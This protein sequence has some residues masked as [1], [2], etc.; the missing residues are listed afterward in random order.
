[1]LSYLV[2][3]A[4]I[5]HNP[6]FV[7]IDKVLLSYFSCLRRNDKR[8]FGTTNY[9]AQALGLHVGEVEK[10]MERIESVGLIIRESDNTLWLPHSLDYLKAWFPARGRDIVVGSTISE[11]LN[12]LATILS[13][14]RKKASNE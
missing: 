10:R 12:K 9:L 3:P 7:A 6:S 11:H 2:I 1:M 5:L 8:F 13:I 14:D 4:E